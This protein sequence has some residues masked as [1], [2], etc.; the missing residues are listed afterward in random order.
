[1]IKNNLNYFFF[2][3]L[4]S[5][6][7]FL[8]NEVFSGE[9][10]NFLSLKKNEVNLRQGPSFEYPV[11]LTYKKKNLPVII[12][13]KSDAWKKIK[14][15]ENNS[16]WIH[17]SQLSKKRTAINYKNN[18]ILFKKPSIYSK[19]IVKL[20]SGRLVLVNKC[21]LKWCKIT[22]GNFNG[23]VDKSSLWGSVK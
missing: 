15:F 17:V 10:I 13:D 19:P 11:I 20:E 7:L 9:N 18:S 23:W 4:L 8:P 22:S 3:L 14:D 6:I 21:N 2:L 16:G 1:M 12:L 5:L